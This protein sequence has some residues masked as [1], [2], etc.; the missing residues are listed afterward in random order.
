M[1]KLQKMTLRDVLIQSSAT[2]A[3]RPALGNVD[4]KPDHH[5][6]GAGA[7]GRRPGPPAPGLRAWSRE[8]GWSCSRKTARSGAW[9]TWA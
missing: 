5:L 2:Y 6:R 4:D 7:P 9:P 8:T 3:E 1:Y